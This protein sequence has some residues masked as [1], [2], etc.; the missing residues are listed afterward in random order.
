MV[1]ISK[2]FSAVNMK[3]TGLYVYDFLVNYDS[4]D[5]DYILSVFMYLTLSRLGRGLVGPEAWTFFNNFLMRYR[6]D[7]KFFDFS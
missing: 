6:I 4:I 1:N 5:V 3:K 2:Y 7:L